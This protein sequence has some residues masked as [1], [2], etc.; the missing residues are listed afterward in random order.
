MDISNFFE[1]YKGEIKKVLLGIEGKSLE[2]GG[3]KT[4]P[5][6]TFEG[7]QGLPV[8]F[9]LEVSDTP[10]SNWPAELYSHYQEVINNPSLWAKKALDYGA[11][12]VCLYLSSVEEEKFDVEKIAQEV[13]N[14]AQNISA[15]LIIMAVGDKD[16]DTKALVEVA[17]QC[18]GMNLLIGPVQKENY[19]EIAQAALNNGHNIIAQTPLDI[20]LCKELNVKLAKFFP[21]EKIV[22]DPL[23]SA[24]GYGMDY[25]FSIMERIKQIGVVH[26]DEMMKMPI[27]ANIAKEVWRQKDVKEDSTQGILWEAITALSLVSAGANIVVMRHPQ[28]LKLVKELI[29]GQKIEPAKEEKLEVKI[30]PE[31]LKTL[32]E[33]KIEVDKELIV[34]SAL[35]DKVMEEIEILKKKMQALE[36][37]IEEKP[38]EE[39]IK[40]TKE[41]SPRTKKEEIYHFINVEDTW[42][43]IGHTPMPEMTTLRRWDMRLLKT[44]K[45]FYAP[46]CDLCCFCTYGKCDLT[47]DKRGACGIDICGQQGRIVLIACLMGCSAHAA[48]ARHLIDYLIEKL[49]QD[50]PIDLGGQV[51]VEAPLT[52]LILGLKPKTLGDLKKVVEYVERG[53]VPAVAATHTGQEGSNL[54]F[55]SKALHIGMLDLLVMEAADIAQIVGFKFPTSIAETSIVGLGWGSIDKTKPVACCVGH[56]AAVSTVMIDYLRQ[57]GNYDKVEVTGIC[58]TALDNTRYSD[59]AKVIGPLSQQLFFLKTGIADL[60]ITDEQCVRCDLPKVAKEVGSALI[61][62]S[63]KICYGLEDVSNKSVDEIIK[64]IVQEDKQVLIL[65]VDKAGEVAA[66]VLPLVAATRK[67]KLITKEE[68]IELSKGCKGCKL[69]DRVCANLLHP[70][71]ALEEVAGGN[72]EKIKKLFSKCIGC[73]KCEQECPKNVPI[74][75]IMQEATSWDEYKVRVGRGPIHDVEIRKVGSPIVLGTIPGV[76]AIVGCSNFPEEID[77]IAQIAEEFAK[78]K[79]IV[80]LSG[81]SAMAAGLKKDKEGKTIYE[82]Y[83]PDFDAGCILNVGSCVANSHIVGAAIKVANIFAKLPLRANFEVIADYILNRVGAVGLAWGAYSQKAASIA[84]GCNRCGI[85]VVVGPHSSKYRRLYLSKKEEDDWTVMDGRTKE[86]VNTQEPSPEHL[87]I[88]VES[89]ERAMITMVKL[90]IRKNDTHQGRQIKLNNYISLYKE[91]MGTLPDDLANFVRTEADIPIVYKKEVITFLKDIGWK[92]KPLLTLPTLIGT[93]ESDIPLDAVISG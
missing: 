15:P 33:G 63:D 40:V 8:A 21:K 76:I 30:K 58:C 37:E 92:P 75:K 80:V 69:C 22:I 42:E 7:E 88:V 51:V 39:K 61:A 3:E 28:S 72:F 10:P 35:F 26:D 34:T 93:Y 59:R 48:H 53:I 13:K 47:G 84:T 41:V 11:D 43:P 73:G 6:H 32:K 17:H 60:I 71:E 1:T 55:E 19:E 65:D 25:S 74:F 12:A 86:L 83:K 45:P 29:S 5:I 23:S 66:K 62:T 2:I 49:G 70:S 91:F 14:V 46:F 38:K 31:L 87:I 68:A 36:V 50:Y 90:C 67:K 9:A 89:K 27:M 77:E 85:P 64:M 57:T 18:S 78:R 79:Y 16:K 24:L 82:R 54:D 44:Y 20:N 52:R 4:L 81:C 56:N